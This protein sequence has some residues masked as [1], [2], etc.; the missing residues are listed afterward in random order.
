VVVDDLSR[1]VAAQVAPVFDEALAALS[2]AEDEVRLARKRRSA[3]GAEL[4]AVDAECV[5]ALRELEEVRPAS[6]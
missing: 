4:D 1:Q 6:R 3:A 2:A 5:A